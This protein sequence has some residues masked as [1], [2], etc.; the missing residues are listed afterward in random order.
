[1]KSG[2]SFTTRH[3]HACIRIANVNFPSVVSSYSR[4]EGL[5]AA[6]LHDSQCLKNTRSALWVIRSGEAHGRG[7][8][9]QPLLYW[10]N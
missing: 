4:I 7:C 9:G 6:A 3:D 1:M 10:A 5:A 8:W 2:L